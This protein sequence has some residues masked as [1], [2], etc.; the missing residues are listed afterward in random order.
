MLE[1]TAAL[2]NQ[3]AAGRIRHLTLPSVISGDDA[4]RLRAQIRLRPFWVADRGRYH[5]SDQPPEPALLERLL[6]FSSSLTGAPFALAHHRWLRFSRGDYQ[7][8]LGD[9]VERGAT[10]SHLELTLD[11]S[12]A[13]TGQAEIVYTDGAESLTI[14]QLAGSLTLVE[15]HDSLYRYERY[16]NH[17]VGDAEVWRLRLSLMP[18]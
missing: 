1:A 14:P 9:A 13:D 12:A 4:P 6:S 15:R 7:L 2:R 11:L 16:L 17:K 5:T 8:M 3:F 18:R 10:G